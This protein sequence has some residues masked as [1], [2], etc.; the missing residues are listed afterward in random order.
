MTLTLTVVCERRRI[1]RSS[2]IIG[3][4][5]NVEAFALEAAFRGTGRLLRCDAYRLVWD[6]RRLAVVA[7]EAD[8][9]LALIVAC[10]NDP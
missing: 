7:I 9:H 2:D 5:G 8:L 1:T 4:H 3:N 6:Q 10:R